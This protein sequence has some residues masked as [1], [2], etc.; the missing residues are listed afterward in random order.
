MFFVVDFLASLRNDCLFEGDRSD[1]PVDFVIKNF[2]ASIFSV[3]TINNS[4]NLGIV[5]NETKGSN[6]TT[7]MERNQIQGF[8]VNIQ[9]NSNPFRTISG[10]RLEMTS[11]HSYRFKPFVSFESIPFLALK[12]SFLS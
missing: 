3:Y 7:I 10:R 6:E 12:L 8:R 4:C 9:A 5:S 11:F 1:F 2:V